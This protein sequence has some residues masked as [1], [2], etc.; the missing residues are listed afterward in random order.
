MFLAMFENLSHI[1]GIHTV[2]GS[3]ALVSFW[4]AALTRKGSPPHLAAG[5]VYLLSMSGVLLTTIPIVLHF[6]FAGDIKRTISLIY[7]F[8]VTVSAMVMLFFSIRRK[9]RLADYRNPLYKSF[10]IFMIV[11]GLFIFCL[12]LTHPLP[13]RKVL[14]FGFSSLGLVIGGSMLKLAWARSID[15]MWWL[16][17]HLNGVMIAFA[18]T[19]ASFLGLGL[20]KLV[21]VLAGDWMHVFTQLGT[22]GLAY[23]LRI[24]LGKRMLAR[25][26][27]RKNK[28]SQINE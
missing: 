9:T 17:Q 24:Y 7:L 10:G 14:L 12:A 19:H 13:A 20:K 2:V 26:S 27:S 22:I 11:F 8:F 23:V 6:Y 18:A 28:A 16:R 21:P 4:V 5:R 1:L 3:T 25:F 15:E